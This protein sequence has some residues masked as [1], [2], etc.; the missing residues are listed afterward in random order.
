[1]NRFLQLMQLS[2]MDL[3]QQI[4]TLSGG[5]RARVALAQALLSGA[6]TVLLDEPTNH[7]DLTSIQVMERALANFPGAIVVVSHDRFFIDKVATRLLLFEGPGQVREFNGNWSL[8]QAALEAGAERLMAPSRAAA[9]GRRR[10][11]AR[12]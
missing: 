8:Y 12:R 7:L 4:G 1:M 2:E 9:R 11:H 5:Q 3:T 10:C 6:G